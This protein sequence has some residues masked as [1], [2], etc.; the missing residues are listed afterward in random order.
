MSAAEAA[1]WLVPLLPAV[2]GVALL[3]AGVGNRTAPVI[4]VAT[5]GVTVLLA[6]TVGLTGPTVTAPFLPGLDFVLRVDP[7]SALVAPTVALVAA[8]VLAS[9][10]ADIRRDTSRFHGLML[11]FAS[12]ALLTATAGT[13][14]TLLLGWEVMGATSYALIGFAWREERRVSAGLTA[15]LTTRGADLGLY[16]AA[17]AAFAGGAGLDLGGLADAVPGWRD[18]IAAGIVLA[19]LGKAAQLPFSFWLS[20][21]MQGPSP[22]SALLHSAAMVALG[23]YL[24]LRVSPLLEATGW[25]GPLVAWVG[26]GTAVALGIVA[27]GQQDLKQLLAASTASQL[28]FV[29]LAAGLGAVAAGTAHL[30]AH[31]ATKAAL[32]LAAG[33]WLTALGTRRLSALSGVARRW[34][35]TGVAFTVAALALAGVPPLSLW[36]TKD[37]VLAAALEESGWLYGVGLLATALSAAY[38]AKMVWVVWARPPMVAERE[39][40]WDEE[41]RGTRAVASTQYLPVAVLAVGAAVLGILALPP[42]GPVVAAFLGD[43]TAVPP[44][45]LELLIS[46]ALALA[47]L[48]SLR[49]VRLPE[50]TWARTWLGMERSVHA[51]LVRPAL[52]LATVLARFDDRIL[53]RG[54]EAAAIGTV[55]AARA[56][57]RVDDAVLD[58]SVDATGTGTLL[59][60]EAAARADDRGVDGAVKALA[61][62][63]RRAGGAARRPQSGLLHQYYLQAVAVLMAVGAVLLLLSI[64]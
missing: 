50:P 30:V 34:T 41:E 6:V 5:A 46:A 11:L 15:F 20:G 26:A 16:V 63:V 53:D 22:V 43:A 57:G 49:R 25:A 52:A 35:I 4:S 51:A 33:A 3:V 44:A 1:L 19:A 24:L 54:V 55:R 32:F 38:A 59:A 37:A 7:L 12:A 64:G 18:I 47:V 9:S 8:L 56:M 2:V 45:P 10:V 61:A 62:A 23:S 39:R 21:A 17:G 27:V 58:R 28:G 40:H 31:A 48:L 29:V 60:G 14:P 42:L 36:A 13:L